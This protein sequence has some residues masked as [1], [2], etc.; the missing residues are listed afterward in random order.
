MQKYDAWSAV[1]NEVENWRMGLKSLTQK[2]MSP[3]RRQQSDRFQLITVAG[4]SESAPSSR[5]AQ[6]PMCRRLPPFQVL[7]P[8]LSNG[9]SG[10]KRG[11]YAR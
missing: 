4:R 5:C 8:R 11:A 7:P 6:R 10:R 9:R 1:E 2:P 3:I